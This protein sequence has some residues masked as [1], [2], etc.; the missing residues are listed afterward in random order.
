MRQYEQ[1]EGQGHQGSVNFWEFLN[2]S[3]RIFRLADN[4]PPVVC[5]LLDPSANCDQGSPKNPRF[6]KNENENFIFIK[7]NKNEIHF[8]KT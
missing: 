5:R 3:S 8:Q 4:V 1:S 2:K 7:M 6:Y